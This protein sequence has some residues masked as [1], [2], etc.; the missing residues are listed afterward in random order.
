ML[1]ERPVDNFSIIVVT[2]IPAVRI[3]IVQH[4]KIIHGLKNINDRQ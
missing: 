3:E 4:K 1:E 2:V